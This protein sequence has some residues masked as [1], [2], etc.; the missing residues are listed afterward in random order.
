MRSVSGLLQRRPW[1][2]SPWRDKGTLAGLVKS[3]STLQHRSPCPEAVE[4]V[5]R[6]LQ[7]CWFA[8]HSLDPRLAG[9]PSSSCGCL[10]L[11]VWDGTS[12]IRTWAG[13]SATLFDKIA[14]NRLASKIA[15]DDVPA[16]LPEI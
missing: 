7:D 8:R 14:E 2:E 11:S 4:T 9:I 10:G 15:S 16:V 1:N 12:T 13:H 6:H 3:C 5:R